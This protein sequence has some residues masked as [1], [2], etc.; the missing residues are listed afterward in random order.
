MNFDN[1]LLSKQAEDNLAKL[2]NCV[3]FNAEAKKLQCCDG[4]TKDKVAHLFRLG[5]QMT[6]DITPHSACKAG[7]SYCCNMAVSITLAEAKAISTHT[8][9]DKDL[10]DAESRKLYTGTPCTFLVEG[11]CSVYPV[12][13]VACRT[14]FN[15][16]DIP[17]LCD[18]VSYPK[19]DVP[20]LNTI[21]VKIAQVVALRQPFHDLRQ[22]FPNNS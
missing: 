21:Q 7:C 19:Q 11:K 3:D 2:S 16:S 22:F 10:S 13:P 9:P 18:V 6:K 5:D 20:C 8:K 12:R 14:Y 4:S 1:E 15:M 17:T